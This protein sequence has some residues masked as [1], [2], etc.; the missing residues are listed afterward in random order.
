MKTFNDL[1][2]TK[3]PNG[4]DGAV[5]M[6]WDDYNPSCFYCEYDGIVTSYN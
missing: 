1:T 2:F 4:I 5:Q 6:C 3:H